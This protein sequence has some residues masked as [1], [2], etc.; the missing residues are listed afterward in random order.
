MDN[1]VTINNHLQ[2][3]YS[4]VSFR[5]AR[6]GGHGGQNVNKVE[7]KVELLFDVGKSKSLS[8]VQRRQVTRK[9]SSRID[10]HGVLRIVA[11]DSRSQWRNRVEAMER[12]V[13][14]MRAALKPAKKRIATKLPKPAREKRLEEKK[15]RGR[16]KQL[17]RIVEE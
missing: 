7:T 15:R 3:P 8:D 16:I 4:E 14:L 10:S 5:F 12:F 6:S 13:E 2:L 17:R 1:T 9:L 11:Q